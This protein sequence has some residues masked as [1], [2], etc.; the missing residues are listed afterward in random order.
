MGGFF[1]GGG[2][3][4]GSPAPAPSQPAPP[5]PKPPYEKASREKTDSRYAG[6]KKNELEEAAK[7][8][9]KK[10]LGE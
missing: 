4:G 2:G 10:L 5:K 8:A 9:K 3:G 1:G 6:A 7:I